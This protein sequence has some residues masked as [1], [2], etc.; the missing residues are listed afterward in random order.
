MPNRKKKEEKFY[1]TKA[2]GWEKDGDY[3]YYISVVLTLSYDFLVEVL[4]RYEN[5][6]NDV[7]DGYDER[8]ATLNLT[9]NESQYDNCDFMGSV[10][11]KNSGKTKKSK[12]RRRQ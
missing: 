8:Y 12:K 11:F 1:P 4:E 6:D 9:L 7:V 5:G 2:V 3:G 10:K